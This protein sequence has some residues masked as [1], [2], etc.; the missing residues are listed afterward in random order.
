MKYIKSEKPVITINNVVPI[1]ISAD[2]LKMEWLIVECTTFIANNLYDMVKVP[3]DM[4]NISPES[5]KLISNQVSLHLLDNFK[6]QRDCLLSKLF[7]NKFQD[8]VN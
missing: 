2:F 8:M 5:M 6:D 7:M 1:L 3:L 4:S